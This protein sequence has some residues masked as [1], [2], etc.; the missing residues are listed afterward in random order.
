MWIST[1]GMMAPIV[2]EI[3]LSI[4]GV[5]AKMVS[6]KFLHGLLSYPFSTEIDLLETSFHPGVDRKCLKEIQ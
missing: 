3:E 1:K 6:H 5:R 4:P 2:E